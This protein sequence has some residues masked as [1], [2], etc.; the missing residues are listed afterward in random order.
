MEQQCAES[1]HEKRRVD[2][3]T[4]EQRH[5]N[6]RS[7]HRHG[8]LQSENKLLDRVDAFERIDRI[9]TQSYFFFCHSSISSHY[10]SF[11]LRMGFSRLHVAYTQRAGR[12]NKKPSKAGTLT[13]RY[14]R[15]L[16]QKE[17]GCTVIINKMTSYSIHVPDD[18][19]HTYP[20]FYSHFLTLASYSYSARQKL[21]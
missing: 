4:G 19:L 2:V 11:P 12:T 20:P 21:V 7:E 8:L 17:R 13:D 16:S 18:T 10:K 9:N 14:I 6:G 15:I 5:E 3:E 1:G